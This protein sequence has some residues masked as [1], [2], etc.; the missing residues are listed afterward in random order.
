MY[1]QF[2]HFKENPFNLSPDSDYLFLSSVHR[3]AFSHLLYAVKQRKGFVTL[4]GEIGAG[5]TTLC[6]SLIKQLPIGT[7]LAHVLST[8]LSCEEL[9]RSILIDFGVTV[10]NT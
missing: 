4:T 2:F 7:Q 10:S 3:E 6:R 9:F 5:K 1:E 8:R